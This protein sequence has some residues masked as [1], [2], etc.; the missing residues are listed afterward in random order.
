MTVPGGPPQSRTSP[1]T[2]ALDRQ[3]GADLGVGRPGLALDPRDLGDRRQ[4]LAAEA[5]G[6]DAEQVVGVGEL[7]GGV[8]PEGQR[9]VVALHAAAV[10]GDADEVLAAALDGQLDPRRAGV[11]GVLQQFLDHAGRSLDH[12]ARGDLVDDRRRQFPDDP[13]D[14]DLAPGSNRQ[15]STILIVCTLEY[16][17]SKTVRDGG[18]DCAGK[19]PQPTS[20]VRVRPSISPPQRRLRRPIPMKK[21][22]RLFLL[23]SGLLLGSTTF[24]VL[25]LEVL[26]RLLGLAPPLPTFQK[27]VP[28]PYLPFRMKPNLVA[29]QE[30][31]EFRYEYHTN[32]IGFQ[33][34]EHPQEKPEGV[35]RILALGDSYTFGSGVPYEQ[36]YLRRLETMLNERTG[37]H[38]RV[39]ILKFGIGRYFPEAE[40]LLLEHYGLD[41]H[42]DLVL[43]A[44]VPNDVVDTVLGIDAVKVSP[45]GFLQ[46]KESKRVGKLGEWLYLHSHLSRILIRKYLQRTAEPEFWDDIYIADGRH[47]RDWRRVE[48]EYATMTRL[49][50]QH[51]AGIAFINIPTSDLK[52]YPGRRLAQ[53][54][55]DQGVPLIDTRP[56][57][58]AAAR[59]GPVYYELDGHCNADGYAAIARCLA[60]ELPSRGLVP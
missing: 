57:L 9:Q 58:E 19:P 6:P 54:A 49:A 24:G 44:F 30:A 38:P 41:Y 5:Q 16:C 4:G 29:M 59:R 36:T 37:E 14:T 20:S 46:S 12:L 34:E 27:M 2:P 32:S 25:L 60:R 35:F 22:T 42:P 1:I 8:G 7:A 45:S 17:P 10:V 21:T 15:H 52:P 50:H 11:D 43:V 23:R 18:M 56:D 51:D 26:V 47:E 53:W 55:E 13:H 33:D 48:Q 31:P 40:R 3:L 39:E 28:D